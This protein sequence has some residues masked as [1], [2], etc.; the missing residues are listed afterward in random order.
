MNM[1]FL[2]LITFFALVGCNSNS[3]QANQAPTLPETKVVAKVNTDDY[4]ISKHEDED[5]ICY[6]IYK[7]EAISISCIPKKK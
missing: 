3:S 7:I 5:A 1:K 6:T 4:T 2:A